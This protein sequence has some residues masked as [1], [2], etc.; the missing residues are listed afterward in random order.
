MRVLVIGSGGVGGYIT[1]FLCKSGLE[2]TLMSRGKRFDFI[3]NNGLILNTDGKK[4]KS[5]NFNLINELK[6]KVSFDIIINTVKL[7]DFNSVLKDILLKVE[8]NFILLPFQ[9]GIYA[10]EEIKNEI[11][12]NKT[13][14]AVAQISS[15]IN[16]RNQEVD[17]VGSL[18]TFLV[19]PYD[20]FQSNLLMSF[21]LKCQQHNLNLRYKDNIK[22]KI[23]EKFIFLSAYS[24]ITTLNERTIGEIFESINLKRKFIKA[25]EETYN[26]SKE[27]DI[28]FDYNP[29]DK[30]ISK[31]DNMPYKM[32]SSM[33]IDYNNKKKL[34]LDWLSGFIIDVSRKKGLQCQTHEEI[35]NG[36][37]TK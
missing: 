29:V 4:L 2:I 20:N 21:C 15:S 35:F 30:W 10:E 7:Y 33:F 6:K 16:Q 13:Y 37:K 11:G 24:G 9:N 25:M 5:S 14:G 12:P 17:H 28:T 36:I 26:L 19:G 32:T 1:S 27:F 23:W 3:K 22:Q 18:A 8:N 34:E 31:I